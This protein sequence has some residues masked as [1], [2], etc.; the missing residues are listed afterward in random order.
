MNE[1]EFQNHFYNSTII[2]EQKW[3]YVCVSE[4]GVLHL[5]HF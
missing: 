1:T 3:K 5:P 4:D 2:E